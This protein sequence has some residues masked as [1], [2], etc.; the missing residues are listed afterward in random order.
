MMTPDDRE[1]VVD[2]LFEGLEP[3][4]P[5]QHLRARVLSA[6]RADKPGTV[7]LWTRI[8]NHRGLR[9]AWAAALVILLAGHVLIDSGMGVG[10]SS[11]DPGLV[12]E[13]RVDD[14]IVDLL[15]PARISDNVQPIVG[16]L[17]ASG[18]L[19]DFEVKGNPS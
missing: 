12:A 2:R 8:W 18:D 9:L 5:P 6:A 7:D 17:A 11:P 4:A 14:D 15:R 13:N 3:P 16:L 1:P 19:T 10:V